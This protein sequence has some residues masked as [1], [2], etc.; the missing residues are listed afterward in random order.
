MVG[1]YSY[2]D[3]DAIPPP[4]FGKLSSFDQLR[5]GNFLLESNLLSL[6]KKSLPIQQI[7]IFCHRPNVNKKV[8]FATAMNELGFKIRDSIIKEGGKVW[9]TDSNFHQGLKALSGDHGGISSEANAVWGN[10]YDHSV[11]VSGQKHVIIHGTR[12][13]CDDDKENDH[14][15][16]IFNFYVRWANHLNALWEMS[17][18]IDS[19]SL[20]LHLW[21]Q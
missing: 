21:A 16:G 18:F 4:N 2:A 10:I 15:G 9:V 3:G 1:N 7:R 13:D 8:H 19:G 5:T 6:I 17:Y 12:R 11:F 20:G 14:F